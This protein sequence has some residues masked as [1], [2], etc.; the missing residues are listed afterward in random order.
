VECDKYEEVIYIY[1]IINCS[2]ID[3][4]IKTAGSPI[5]II[6]ARSSISVK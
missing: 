5:E 6:D 4:L 1:N 3:M 2:T